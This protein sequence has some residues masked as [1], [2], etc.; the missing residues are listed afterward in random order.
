M[1]VDHNFFYLENAYD[2]LMEF[3]SHTYYFAYPLIIKDPETFY[4]YE[5]FINIIDNHYVIDFRYDE[6]FFF[7]NIQK[8]KVIY[9][10]E[11]RENETIENY[12]QRIIKMG[13]LYKANG[14]VPYSYLYDSSDEVVSL[15]FKWMC[16]DTRDSFEKYI[17]SVPL[18]ISSETRLL[19]KQD[20][21]KI[22]SSHLDFSKNL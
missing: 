19:L 20:P 9:K 13:L 10:M 2:C 16:A 22:G 18:K 3:K 17:G 6:D 5:R 15:V 7:D 4:K 8:K 11:K 14:K 12:R 1:F 21:K